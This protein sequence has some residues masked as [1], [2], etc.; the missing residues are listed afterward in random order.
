MEPSVG[1]IFNSYMVTGTAARKFGSTK[2]EI[3]N[4]AL[5]HSIKKRKQLWFPHICQTVT[6]E[7]C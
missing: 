5:N 3:I 6:A 7:Q 2:D 4:S 1:K